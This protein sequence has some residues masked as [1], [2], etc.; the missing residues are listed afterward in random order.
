[1]LAGE[2]DTQYNGRLAHNLF[3]LSG[4]AIGRSAAGCKSKQ[5]RTDRMGSVMEA[6]GK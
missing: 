1:M 3:A 2:R 4:I 6:I 5:N